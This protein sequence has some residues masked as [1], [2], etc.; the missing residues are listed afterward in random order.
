MN[1]KTLLAKYH[2]K[3]KLLKKEETYIIRKLIE[4]NDYKAQKK[5]K[6]IDF[7]WKQTIKCVSCPKIITREEANWCHWFDKSTTWAYR[8][9]REE[10]NI[11]AWCV[12]C[13]NYQ[14]ER[15]KTNFTIYQTQRYWLPRVEEKQR[16]FWKTHKKP[17][18]EELLK[19]NRELTERLKDN[20]P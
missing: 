16:E 15:H 1:I 20:L 19:T 8:C 11:R 6:L 13:N 9:R 18:I 12:E 5:A 17:W 3:D 14:K 7:N 10:R 4:D 2:N